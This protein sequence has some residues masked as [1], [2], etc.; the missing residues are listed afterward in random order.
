MDKLNFEL[1]RPFGMPA[2]YFQQTLEGYEREMGYELFRNLH[3]GKIY[4]VEVLRTSELDGFEGVEYVRVSLHINE[5]DVRHLALLP[6]ARRLGLA[7]RLRVL[8]T[9]RVPLE[10]R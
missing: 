4:S 5:A 8:F 10:I 6:K 9:G 1:K 3:V 2:D 7:E